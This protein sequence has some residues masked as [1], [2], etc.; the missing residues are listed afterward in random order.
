MTCSL[1]SDAE[2]VLLQA[3]PGGAFLRSSPLLGGRA[4]LSFLFSLAE[5]LCDGLASGSI[6]GPFLSLREKRSDR[7]LI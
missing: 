4:V 5:Y 3:G 7:L 1:F 6:L 2:E